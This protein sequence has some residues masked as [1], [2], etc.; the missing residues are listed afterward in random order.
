MGSMAGTVEGG[1]FIPIV[2]GPG[3]GVLP[4][5]CAKRPT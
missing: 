1:G 4:V 5:H 2:M 3:A